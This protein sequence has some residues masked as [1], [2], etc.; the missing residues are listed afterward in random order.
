MIRVAPDCAAPDGAGMARPHGAAGGPPPLH[1]GAG[2]PCRR[3]P[4]PAGW[5]SSAQRPPA[6]GE[7]RRRFR[8]AVARAASA[9]V[10]PLP[11]WQTANAPG[12]SNAVTVWQNGESRVSGRREW[13]R[14]ESDPRTSCVP[15]GCG[16]H[17]EDRHERSKTIVGL[18]FLLTVD[19]RWQPPTDRSFAHRSR[20][21][22]AR[23]RRLA[24]G[25]GRLRRQERS[26]RPGPPCPEAAVE[27]TGIPSCWPRASR[28]PSAGHDGVGSDGDRSFEHPV[29]GLVGDDGQPD[30]RLHQVDDGPKTVR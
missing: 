11:V 27:S 15:S 16:G 7:S 30:G 23:S 28:P 10:V 9:A 22:R 12:Q 14:W 8:E 1:G 25:C 21:D 29:V 24:S 6:R 13:R 19:G 5:P 3:H 20:T 17:P 2:R 4:R 26:A 18:R